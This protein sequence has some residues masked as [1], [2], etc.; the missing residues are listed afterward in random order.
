MEAIDHSHEGDDMLDPI[1]RT[2]DYQE[3]VEMAK[4]GAPPLDI[5]GRM[6][7]GEFARRARVNLG[8]DEYLA[9]LAASQDQDDDK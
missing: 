5:S 7:T 6:T 1:R 2:S 4:S 3:G 9:R 8:H